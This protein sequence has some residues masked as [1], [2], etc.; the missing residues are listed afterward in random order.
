MLTEPVRRRLTATLCTLPILVFALVVWQHR[1]MTDDGFINLRVVQQIRAGNGP[2]YNTGQRV[3]AFTSPLW[4][5][6]LTVG[7]LITPFRLEW[8]AVLSGIAGSVAGFGFAIA[9]SVRLWR[10]VEPDAVLV[11]LGVLIPLALYPMWFF[12]SSGLEGGL[13]FG[14]LGLSVFLLGLWAQREDQSLGSWTAAI[15]GL[16]WV[17]RPELVLLS[18]AFLGAALVGQSGQSWRSRLRVG[19]A[20]FAIP[21]AYQVFRMGYYGSLLANTAYAKNA[22]ASHWHRGYRYLADFVGTYE[23]WIPIVLLAAA[24]YLPMFLSLRA[25]RRPR[26]ALVALAF[27]IG[28]G[29]NVIYI[30]KVGGDYIHARLLLPALFAMCIPVAVVA[31]KR[32]YLVAL[33]VVPWSVVCGLAIRPAATY[34]VTLDNR[35]NLVTVNQILGT[36]PQKA[37]AWFTGRGI[38]WDDRRL[39]YRPAR[40]LD[41]PTVGRNFIGVFG[42]ALGPNVDVFDALGLADPLTAR[43]ITLRE[44]APGHEKPIPPPWAAARLTSS[45]SRTSPKDFRSSGLFAIT[46]LIPETHGAR[47]QQQVRIA[48]TVLRCRSITDFEKRVTEPMS[49]GR[50]FDN[51]GASLRSNS[52]SIPPDP[53][54]AR[55]KLCS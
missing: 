21:F 22:G 25:T 5:G 52:F 30:V 49:V 38:Y 48:R 9:G 29:L 20:M 34:R 17:I 28:G 2:V 47:F 12:A 33:A 32:R 13:V 54:A 43:F 39:P 50:F 23:L 41:R 35:E 42:Y 8:V 44:G 53:A 10:T 15:L 51:L 36:T 46:P 24:A 18:V 55:R 31:I 26:P 4:I 40:D 19:A 1:W 6:V 37:F 7:D 11:P 14:W 45:G 3:E 27:A 16:G